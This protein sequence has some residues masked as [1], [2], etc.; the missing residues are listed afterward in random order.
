[1]PPESP[2]LPTV[3]VLPT[4]SG[5]PAYQQWQSRLP[6]AS[7]ALADSGAAKYI[8]RMKLPAA[9]FAA[10][11]LAFSALLVAACGPDA[12]LIA[13]DAAATAPDAPPPTPASATAADHV[14]GA[15]VRVSP[16]GY[17]AFTRPGAEANSFA[18]TARLVDS[19]GAS[20]PIPA[21]GLDW[22]LR[23]GAAFRVDGD[24]VAQD[25]R[26]AKLFLSAAAGG[27]DTV[28]A[29]HGATA[30][31]AF[32]ENW[33]WMPLGF[34]WQ[35]DQW[36]PVGESRCT[37]IL[38][39]SGTAAIDLASFE[40]HVAT[41]DP[42]ALRLD[43]A[44]MTA[45]GRSVRICFTA[46][47]SGVTTLALAGRDTANRRFWGWHREHV[48][49][50]P[51]L[52][53]GFEHG[54]A[55]EIGV[56]QRTHLN[57]RV[58]DGHGASVLLADKAGD[59]SWTSNDSTV[60]TVS[61]TGAVQGLASGS[62]PVSAAYRNLT[63]QATVDVYEITGGRV[64]EEIVC[65]STRR[66]AV[67]C[68]GN[69][70]Q[71]LLGYA[72]GYEGLGIVRPVQVA[73]V[74]VGA[75]VRDFFE[76]SGQA[77]CAITT[78]SLLRCWGNANWG[79][80]GYGRDNSVGRYE[81]PAAAGPVPLGGTPAY[82]GGGPADH[83]CTVLTSGGLRCVGSNL[84]GQ[85]GYGIP[86]STE[87]VVGDDETPATM[88]DVPLGGKAV[89]VATGGRAGMTCAALDNGRGRC[90]GINAQDWVP[91]TNTLERP[92][93]GL[94]YGREI[95][96]DSPIGDDE[97]P[98]DAGDLP[99][100]GRIVQF[101]LGGYHICAV[102][103]GGSVRCWGGNYNGELG[104]GLGQRQ[105]VSDA[106]ESVELVFPSPVVQIK[107]GWS[108][109]CVLMEDGAVRCWGGND[110]GALGLGDTR[111]RRVAEFVDDVPLG[112]PA[113]ALLGSGIYE[114]CAVMQAGGLRCWGAN[115]NG[116]FGYPFREDVGDNETPAEVGDI[117]VFP[118]PVPRSRLG[119]ASTP[120][121]DLGA[122]S[123]A[124]GAHPQGVRPRAVAFPRR[125]PG[126][127]PPVLVID[128]PS[129]LPPW[130]GPLVGADGWIAPSA[131]PASTAWIKVER[132]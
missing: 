7:V 60:A 29:S 103:D 93:Y 14:P 64:G 92:T 110:H 89:H 119:T 54:G 6:T 82:V 30:D 102:M 17:V 53:L 15:S 122:P 121:S 105:N 85:V 63:A 73:N 113:T 5:D 127:V 42:F 1:M 83:W 49:L 116:H 131:V 126:P 118:G 109:T 24:S 117:M 58:S 52:S 65:V 101:A 36:T 69:S 32:A 68:W 87:P 20:L 115:W 34:Q 124:Q 76:A 99:L 11:A 40:L 35:G 80:L 123:P 50:A 18:F 128:Q 3:A 19:A 107:A 4:D 79:A 67:R 55:Y 90:W 114:N 95:G 33:E 21:A 98:A 62:V 47:R 41:F 2:R 120:G 28:V 108:H 16:V 44:S 132:P 43:S 10:G 125:N 12:P 48:V 129:R 45:D 71:Q 26:T 38:Q 51:P 86:H 81:T 25:R 72:V 74:N 88:G 96:Y 66:G 112:G 70:E 84:A 57:A 22:S 78:D 59:V 39:A 23:P 31:T 100:E 46:Q 8:W 56:G 61:A 104:A 91:A 94:G 37:R 77:A 27:R 75:R 13:P 106:G 130:V 111:S 97:T 9:L